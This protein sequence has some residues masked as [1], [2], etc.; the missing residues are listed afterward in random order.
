MGWVPIIVGEGQA[1][2]LI[3]NWGNTGKGLREG[4]RVELEERKGATFY[5][6]F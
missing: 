6:N 1:I 4:T 2:N 5:F 3:W